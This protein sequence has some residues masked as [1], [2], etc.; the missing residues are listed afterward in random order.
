MMSSGNEEYAHPR[1]FRLRHELRGHTGEINRIGWSLDGR[2]LASPSSD[3]TVRLWTPDNGRLIGTLEG[4]SSR[5]FSVAWSP[6]GSLLASGSNEQIIRLWNVRTGE[7]RQ[8]LVANHQWVSSV[9]WSS[10]GKSLATCSGNNTIQLWDTET[11]R[12]RQLL[13]DGVGTISNLA[14]SPDGLVL[15]SGG[16]DGIIRLWDGATGKI[17]QRLD[18]KCKD[19]LAVTWSVDGKTLVS[20]S[21]DSGILIWNAVT[22]WQKE[23]LSGHTAPV[24]SAAFSHD[25]RLLASKSADGTVR[26]WRSDIWETVAVIP[27]LSSNVLEPSPSLAFHPDEPVLATLGENDRVIRIWQV[28]IAKILGSV[29]QP[30]LE[31]ELVSAAGAMRTQRF[32][33]WAGSKRSTLALAFTDIVGSTALGNELGNEAMNEVRLAHFHAGRRLI[34]KYN[35]YL[36]KTIGD[37]LM[38][39]FHTAAE[40]LNF[41]LS[42][43]KNTGHDRVRIRAGINVGVVQIEDDDAFGTMVNYAA[44]VESQAKEDEIWLS[45]RA[46]AD[47]DDDRSKAHEK[48]RWLSHPDCE[49]KGVPGTHVLWSVIFSENSD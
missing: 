5:V 10:D 27:E 19:I 17:L 4:H 39:A 11:W 36:I 28:D 21:L 42:L 24:T 2:I 35:G 9:Q 32:G 20:V 18:A 40:A 38:A 41:A 31:A 33:D 6:D 23:D 44:R 43:H 8:A 26:I 45:E 46:K 48:L 13:R 47:V 25:G 37:S 15:A 16:R 49:L 29:S 1:G 12:V 3:H 34:E 30:G 14:W 7:L 22:G